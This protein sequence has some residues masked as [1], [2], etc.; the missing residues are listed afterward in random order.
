MRIK[1]CVFMDYDAMLKNPIVLP[2]FAVFQVLRHLNS[3]TV[4]ISRLLG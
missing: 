3:E 4:V 2:N 1:F